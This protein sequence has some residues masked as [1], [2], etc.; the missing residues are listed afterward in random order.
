MNTKS[1]L[2]TLFSI[3]GFRLAMENERG[4]KR[5]PKYIRPINYE[6]TFRPDLEKHT[7]EGHAKIKFTIDHN[8]PLKAFELYSSDLDIRNVLLDQMNVAYSAE[9]KEERIKIEPKR[10]LSSGNYTLDI[11]FSGLLN[12]KMHGFYRSTYQ[13]EGKQYTLASTQFEPAYAR[14][15]F[16]CWDEPSFKATFDVTIEAPK[17]LTPMLIYSNGNGENRMFFP[18]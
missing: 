18:N 4:F 6:L 3:L 2:L 14:K 8:E 16:P 1:A 10:E 13:R 12:D 15:A 9:P 17:D 7:F 5:L 11:E